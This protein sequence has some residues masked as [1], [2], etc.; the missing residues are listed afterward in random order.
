VTDDVLGAVDAVVLDTAVGGRS[1]GTGMVFD[2]AGS[3]E[4]VRAVATRVPVILAGGLRP[5][6]VRDA[7]RVLAPH[8]VD[9]SSGVES[10]PGVKDH[11][12]MR[13]FAESARLREVR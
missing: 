7:V 1:G 13:A 6:N 8:V 9:V 2:W 4:M 12:L 10:A 11:A 3:S 5:T